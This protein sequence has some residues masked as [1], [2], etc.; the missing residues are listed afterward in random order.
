MNMERFLEEQIPQL[1]GYL[2]D[3]TVAVVGNPEVD[4]FVCR[5]EEALE[6][7][8]GPRPGVRPWL[9]GENTFFWCLDQLAL[10]ADPH[11]GYSRSDP[12]VSHQLADLREMAQRLRARQN[13]PPGRE[14]HFM[15]PFDENHPHWD[16][17]LDG[18][19]PGEWDG[20]LGDWDSEADD[21]LDPDAAP[22][23]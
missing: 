10:L 4:A 21:G 20:E 16:P 7:V 13:L 6:A 12:W 22:R 14:V 8:E 11:S 23:P 3:A 2:D 19:P 9:P 5:L 15:Q 18:E 1:L 17:L